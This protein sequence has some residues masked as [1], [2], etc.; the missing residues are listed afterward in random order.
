[1]LQ[2][3]RTWLS[4]T[5]ARGWLEKRRSA[6]IYSPLRKNALQRRKEKQ[7]QSY[8][9]FI[10]FLLFG[11]STS[12]IIIFLE[13]NVTDEKTALVVIDSLARFSSIE[14]S[15]LHCRAGSPNLFNMSC[16]LIHYSQE[17]NLSNQCIWPAAAAKMF[18]G[19]V[20]E[21]LKSSLHWGGFG[22][23]TNQTVSG[24]VI[25]DLYLLGKSYKIF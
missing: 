18:V 22:Y 12:V 7:N 25:P 4:S 9:R 24:T 8:Q 6:S 21:I 16:C 19:K 15:V 13:K 23:S 1:M 2:W 3:F 20:S 10:N 5:R 11:G 17:C 14:N